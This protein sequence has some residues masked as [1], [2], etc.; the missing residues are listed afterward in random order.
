MTDESTA[1]AANPARRRALRVFAL[2]LLTLALV[3]FGRWF[4]HGRFHV[5]TDDAAVAGD[6]VSV[7]PQVSATV[8]RILVEDTMTVHAGDVVV[9]LDDTDLRLNRERAE[10]DLRRTVQEVQ[11]LVAQTAAYAAEAASARAEQAVVEID[12]DHAAADFARRQAA[13]ADGGVMGEELAHA[14]EAKRGAE[15]RLAAAGRRVES[16]ARR[17]EAQAAMTQGTDVAHHPRVLLA[18]A[19]LRQA[20]LAEA[21]AKV[22]AP[23]DGVVARRGPRSRRRTARASA[24]AS[25]TSRT[26]SSG[27]PK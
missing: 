17:L 22:R 20:L 21:R 15:A 13:A 5:T 3:F 8:A 18:A 16:A 26:R 11:A 19:T 1:P 4:L 24:S 9:V 25:S 27:S 12:R 14:E 2:V 6:I 23:I 7:T 10:A